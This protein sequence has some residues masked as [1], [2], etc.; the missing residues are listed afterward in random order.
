MTDTDKMA[1]EEIARIICGND[2]N[3]RDCGHNS[4]VR[5]CGCL[6]YAK[7]I[8]EQDYRKQSEGEWLEQVRVSKEGKPLLRHY[9]CNL[10]GVYLAT[11]ANY[12]PNCGAKMKG[13]E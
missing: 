12:C 6:F 8:Y 7:R 9:K 13:G 3:C 11:Q 2:R 5:E 10:C 1:I 4:A